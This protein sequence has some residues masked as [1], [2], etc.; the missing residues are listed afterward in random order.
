ML[1][2][3]VAIVAQ[4]TSFVVWPLTEKK[5]VLYTIPAAVILISVGW[6]ENFVSEKSPVPFV[7]NLGKI[8]REFNNKTYFSYAFVAPMKCITFF[9][10]AVVIIW[11]QE[12]NVH[13][14]FDHFFNIFDAH[15][16]TVSEVSKDVLIYNEFY[17]LKQKL[18]QN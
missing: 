10:T 1:L 16:I 7:S 4:A 17:Y 12:G 8:K 11:I 14:M 9:L 5:P 15:D 13:V 6:W 2:D 3:V 18:Y